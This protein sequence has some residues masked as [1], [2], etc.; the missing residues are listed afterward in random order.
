[1][2][3]HVAA[4][5]LGMSAV[6]RGR[7][8]FNTHCAT[9]HGMNLQGTQ[10]AP[11]LLNTGAAMVDFQLRT[12]RM[13]AEG[14]QEQQY[15]HKPFFTKS[16]IAALVAYVMSKSSGE[17]S[18]PSPHVAAAPSPAAL[19]SGREIYE[20]NCEHCHAATGRGDGATGY[21][22]IAPELTNADAQ[23][24]ADAVRV[25]PNVMPVFGSA[26]ISDKQLGDLIAYVR[27]LQKAQYN[28]GGMQLANWGPVS[29][30]FIAWT[31]GIGLLVLLCRRIGEA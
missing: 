18:L 8:I 9:C 27:Y 21:H 17:R 3:L 5:L 15:D 7:D 31:F 20:E 13:P 14:P 6:D 2:M 23:T 10:Y 1:M 16:E 28:P 4:L 12:G 25:G 29:E 24:I 11:P 22:D 19:R 26:A 30:G